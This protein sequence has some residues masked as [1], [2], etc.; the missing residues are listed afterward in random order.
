MECGRNSAGRVLASQAKCRGFE[1]LRP[2]HLESP[3]ICGL[4]I[5]KDIFFLSYILSDFLFS[6]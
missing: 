5:Y 2:L 4:I 6:Y 1:P 3:F